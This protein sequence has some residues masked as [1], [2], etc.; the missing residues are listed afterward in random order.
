MALLRRRAP[1]TPAREA[2][3]LPPTPPTTSA[4]PERTRSRLGPAVYPAPPAITRP[5]R[6]CC[7]RN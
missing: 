1:L 6:Y 2:L 5:I 7:V 3:G 4:E